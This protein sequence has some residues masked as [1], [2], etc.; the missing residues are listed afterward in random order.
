[1]TIYLFWSA[2]GLLV[3]NDTTVKSDCVKLGDSCVLKL[4]LL[5]IL[6]SWEIRSIASF[7][8]LENEEKHGDLKVQEVVPI[9]KTTMF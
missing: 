7:C 8:H 1:M 5:P 4:D 6:S 9:S 3:L 2:A